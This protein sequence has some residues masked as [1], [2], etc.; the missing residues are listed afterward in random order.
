MSYHQPYNQPPPAQQ[1]YGAPPPQQAGYAPP[2]TGYGV[3]PPQ[4]G[5]GMQNQWGGGFRGAFQRPPPPNADPTLWKFFNDVDTDGNGH[6][7]GEELRQALINGDWTPFDLD[8]VQMMLN[9]FDRDMTGTIGFNEFQ[10]LWKYICD[11]QKCFLQFDRDRSGSIS[12][13]ELKQALTAFGYNVSEPVADMLVTKFA[14]RGAKE[15]TFDKFIQICVTVRS[16]TDA[17]RRLDTDSD[18]WVNMNYDT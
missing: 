1:P 18:G 14:K 10:G 7:T 13:T 8:T 5:Y 17:F 6:I 15:I 3:P 4:Q 11:W 2:G 9:M 16:L 12:R